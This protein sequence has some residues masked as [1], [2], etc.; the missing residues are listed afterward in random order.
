MELSNFVKIYNHAVH[1][2]LCH[3]LIEEFENQQEHHIMSGIGAES[4]VENEY[5]KAIEMNCTIVSDNNTEWK[6]LL[7]S[8][9][10]IVMDYQ[11][12]YKHEMN[13]LGLSDVSLPSTNVLEEW[14]LHRYDEGEHFFKKHVDSHDANSSNR[15]LAFL[16][17]LNTVPE[18]GE[19]IF[20][21]H[22]EGIKCEPVQ[23]R[24]LVFPTWFGFP[25][26]GLPVISGTK[27]M[28]KT[29]LHYPGGLELE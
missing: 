28:L 22:L 11:K 19:T 20:T 23:G 18:G 1:P 7:N 6:F 29:Y 15:M 12:L 10:N 4:D 9:N 21:D 14:R 25:H 2:K 16:F 17:Y 27:Y 26:E 8:M 13:K 5:R 24:L 3:D